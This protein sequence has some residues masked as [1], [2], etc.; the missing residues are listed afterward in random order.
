[1]AQVLIY[2]DYG[3]GDLN[4]LYNG[5]K[6]YFEP[7]N[8]LVDYTDAA[9]IIKENALNDDVKLFV[10]PGGAAT[11]F[12]QKLKTYGND[13]IKDYVKNGGNYLG[14]CAGAYFACS[15]V[16][17]EADIK[18]LAIKRNEELLGLVDVSAIGTLHRELH[19]RPYMKNEAAAAAVRLKWVDDEIHY[20][21]Y[22][23]GPKFVGNENHLTVLARYCDVEGQ[24]PAVVFAKYG[25]GKVVLSGVHFEDRGQDLLKT[26]HKMRL[27]FDEASQV[28]LTLQQNEQTRQALFDKMLS[29]FE[30]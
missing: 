10:M 1:M 12:L 20:A 11:P 7:K 18:E 21:H 16:L 25:Q 22:H 14:V 19:I 9:S 29:V 2:R 13:K 8:V 26:L 3:V 4:G 24:P 5:L 30:R 6:Q 28:A 27:D 17:F 23:G 15:K